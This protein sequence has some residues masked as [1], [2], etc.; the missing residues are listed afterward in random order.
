MVALSKAWVCGRSLAGIA[1]SN[2]SG[3]MDVFLLVNVVCCQVDVSATDRSLVQRNP[4]DFG[5]SEY[6]QVQ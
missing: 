4:T 2:P 1:G 5:A 6:N 3:S